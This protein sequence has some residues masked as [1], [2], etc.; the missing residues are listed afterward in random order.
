MHAI[1]LHEAVP[2]SEDCSSCSTRLA[3]WKSGVVANTAFCS[4][5]NQ[6]YYGESLPL[7]PLLLFIT[8]L[9]VRSMLPPSATAPVAAAATAVVLAAT[10]TGA[11]AVPTVAANARVAATH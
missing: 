5:H 2:S 6:R 8:T 10:H 3:F 11:A 9:L 1:Q 4:C 7:Q